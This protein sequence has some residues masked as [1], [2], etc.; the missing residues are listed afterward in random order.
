[1]VVI[2]LPSAA[3]T[4]RMHER[5]ALPSTCTVQAPHC[6]T[7]QPYLVPVRPT[8]SRIAHNKGVLGLTVTS[9]V[10]PL[11]VRRAMSFPPGTAVRGLSDITRPKASCC[12]CGLFLD[13][14][15]RVVDLPPGLLGGALPD[16]LVVAG[17]LVDL[18]PG[19]LHR[20]SFAAGETETHHQARHDRGCRNALAHVRPPGLREPVSFS[21]CSQ[22]LHARGMPG[23]VFAQVG[24]GQGFRGDREPRRKKSRRM[25]S[26][27]DQWTAFTIS[28]A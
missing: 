2:C 23:S 17:D 11:I 7:P 15:D 22:S 5:T 16:Q 28:A 10:L 24:A 25:R 26:A 18:L 8:C 19:L 1:M 4:G 13:V 9:V 3:A 12:F 27:G 14:V 20:P 6:A 21:I